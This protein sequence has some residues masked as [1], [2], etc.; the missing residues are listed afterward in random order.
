[1]KPVEHPFSQE[2][3]MAYADGQVDSRMAAR[4][5]EHLEECPECSAIVKDVKQLSLQ[6]ASW[7]VEECPDTV[8]GKVQMKAERLANLE[9]SSE[10]K[11]SWWSVRRGWVYGLGGAV[12]LFV[13]F[14]VSVPSLLRSRGAAQLPAPLAS[15]GAAEPA[16]L[17]SQAPQGQQ[18]GQAGQAGQQAQPPKVV[19]TIN[20]TMITRTFD[21]ARTKIDEIVRESQGYL[22]RMTVHA[23][24][25]SARS[26]TATL[27]LPAASADAAL[28][29]LK[30]LGRLMQESQNSSDVTSQYVDLEAR[31]SNARNSEQR[32]L[33]LLRERAG[34]L[35]DVVAMEREIS[36]VRES[37]ERME[38]QRK[39]F[40]NKVQFVT[41]QLELSE[42]YHA[43]LEE[44]A[45]STRTELR[46]AAIDGI[47]SGGENII[48]IVLFLL[49]Y[50]PALLV[51]SAV[52]ATFVLVLMKMRGVV[53]HLFQR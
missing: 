27:R 25:G 30:T 13:M 17:Y 5:A 20:L 43:A 51:W 26:L 29:E 8:A 28:N 37:I 12:A 32:L 53:E 4:A 6:L 38:A 18:Q 35:K 34:D 10:S 22:D 48:D 42:E 31:L 1:M 21:A 24:T 3:L 14:S 33:A 7:Q 19:R 50:G 49:R 9:K 23:D 36:S 40:D 39:N 52:V 11:Q 44:P 15:P 45:P 2:E 41:I 47:R 16:V 46:N